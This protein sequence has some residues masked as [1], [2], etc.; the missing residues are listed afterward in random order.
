MPRPNNPNRTIAKQAKFKELAEKRV[1][2]ALDKLRLIGNLSDKKSYEY[3]NDEV[4]AI[5]GFL[6]KELV[7][8]KRKFEP[9]DN[10]EESFI[11]KSRPH[12]D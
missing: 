10:D 9:N 8:I 6:Q 3:S 7:Q 12:L 4:E 5:F 11:L 2:A 1:N